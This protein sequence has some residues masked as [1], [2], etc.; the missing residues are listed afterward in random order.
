MFYWV[1]L[2]FTGL[3]RD[4]QGFTGFY[5]VLLG[6]TGFYC[7]WRYFTRF[8]WVLLGFA[9]F[10]LGYTGF[11]RLF[12]STNG[13]YWLF[14]GLFNG[15]CGGPQNSRGSIDSAGNDFL[16]GRFIFGRLT[17]AAPLDTFRP[18]H[19]LFFF[20]FFSIYI[21]MY[22]YIEPSGKGECNLFSTFF[23]LQER[24]M[25]KKNNN[26][27]LFVSP[28]SWEFCWG[29]YKKTKKTN[30]TKWTPP[31]MPEGFFWCS[32]VL[33]GFPWFQRVLPSFTGF[34]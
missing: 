4:L 1:L 12:T 29:K 27:G 18:F 21:Y 32:W 16:I 10:S 33:L 31:D 9:E 14:N 7:L 13:L 23:L 8:Y 19:F 26:T 25:N 20:I 3:Y 24:K 17:A 28:F 22:I 6:F 11:D 34:Y 15:F 2:G 5:R 30:K